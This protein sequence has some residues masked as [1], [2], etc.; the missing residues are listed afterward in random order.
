MRESAND[1]WTRARFDFINS[2]GDKD[3]AAAFLIATRDAQRRNAVILRSDDVLFDRAN[4]ILKLDR[5]LPT[6]YPE[7]FTDEA[8]D[9]ARSRG[10]A[11]VPTNTYLQLAG[12]GEGLG[13]LMPHHHD[14]YVNADERRKNI[15]VEDMMSRRLSIA[16]ARPEAVDSQ[17]HT[18]SNPMMALDIFRSIDRS[19]PLLSPFHVMLMRNLY[20]NEPWGDGRT[21]AQI[22]SDGERAHEE[23]HKL[24]P[25]N[26]EN[27]FG[28]YTGNVNL[29]QLHERDVKRF[30]DEYL[31]RFKKEP[32]NL[33][34]DYHVWKQFELEGY[35]PWNVFDNEGKLLK[36]DGLL[37]L[38]KDSSQRDRVPFGH[39]AWLWGLES[40]S[41]EERMH[42]G[43]WIAQGKPRDAKHIFDDNGLGKA[44]DWIPFL[45]RQAYWRTGKEAQKC[46]ADPFGPGII[47]KKPDHTGQTPHHE[48][49]GMSDL[50]SNQIES[51]LNAVCVNPDGTFSHYGRR[52]SKDQLTAWEWI[53]KAAS[54]KGLTADHD[55]SRLHLPNLTKDGDLTYKVS[56]AGDHHVDDLTFGHVNEYLKNGLMGP[57]DDPENPE[58]SVFRQLFTPT[59]ING[60]RPF[61]LRSEHG[62][63]V[64]N[65]VRDAKGPYIHSLDSE[66]KPSFSSV[67]DGPYANGG[68]LG[69]DEGAY[70][71]FK[72]EILPGLYTTEGGE[73]M[74]SRVEHKESDD[75]RT[76]AEIE[77][78]MNEMFGSFATGGHELGEHEHGLMRRRI[79]DDHAGVHS[80]MAHDVTDATEER[81]HGRLHNRDWKSANSASINGE[82]GMMDPTLNNARLTAKD[83]RNQ[84]TNMAMVLEMMGGTARFLDEGSDMSAENWLLPVQN[85]ARMMRDPE[86]WATRGAL[87][88]VEGTDDPSE[89]QRMTQIAMI[90]AGLYDEQSEAFKTGLKEGVPTENYGGSF[91]IYDLAPVSH[92]GESASWDDYARAADSVSQTLLGLGGEGSMSNTNEMMEPSRRHIPTFDPRHFLLTNEEGKNMSDLSHEDT[93]RHLLQNSANLPRDVP[94]TPTAL[95]GRMGTVAPEPGTVAPEPG[96]VAPEPGTEEE[97][98]GPHSRHSSAIGLWGDEGGL[99]PTWDAMQGQGQSKP[100][101]HGFPTVNG[102]TH[103]VSH[104]NPADLAR[105]YLEILEDQHSH[106]SIVDLLNRGLSEEEGKGVIPFSLEPLEAAIKQQ[107][108]IVNELDDQYYPLELRERPEGHAGRQ[109][110]RLRRPVEQLNDTLSAVA[111]LAPGFIQQLLKHQPDALSPDINEDTGEENWNRAYVNMLAVCESVERYIL[112]HMTT[113]SNRQMGM[114][115]EIISHTPRPTSAEATEIADPV[116]HERIDNLIRGGHKT[117]LPLLY[118]HVTTPTPGEVAPEPGTEEEATHKTITRGVIKHAVARMKAIRDNPELAAHE[119]RRRGDGR[120]FTDADGNRVRPSGSARELTSQAKAWKQY[121]NEIAANLTDEEVMGVLKDQPKRVKVGDKWEDVH[122]VLDSIS[123]RHKYSPATG[124]NWGG[125]IRSNHQVHTHSETRK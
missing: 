66:G 121:V 10:H 88:Y 68:G 18:D 4:S 71:W 75:E 95:I 103:M 101:E 16:Q 55:E 62:E 118:N 122:E 69:L 24:H 21:G 125:G 57:E 3:D 9:S 47:N 46:R 123:A 100:K 35:R 19:N 112:G 54:D 117:M 99:I 60:G 81:A 113:E 61:V 20:Y 53:K 25:H 109:D 104:D 30:N 84:W 114:P 79:H 83:R 31:N 72:H 73:M 90:E 17:I 56:D 29:H 28:K 86:W 14:G 37:E 36:D 89:A 45:N 70:M 58:A 38:L 40:L 76:P 48:G 93:A 111:E 12:L 1:V 6:D 41:P 92:T 105:R 67:I 5:V 94:R 119:H 13:D 116:T 82:L 7:T 22:Y 32:E 63:K 107:R 106:Y 44:S 87:P 77:A 51:A 11:P 15:Y 34:R 43:H 98:Q 23:A 42:I 102:G 124:P 64:G 97:M 59:D 49:G 8:R 39:E 26:S 80:I 96:T 115:S 50:T 33:K 27:H 74:P 120:T 2:D 85:L 91:N 108:D 78:G 52:D 110:Q 65:L